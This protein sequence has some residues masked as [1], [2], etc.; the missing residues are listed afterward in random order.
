MAH[1]YRNLALWATM[2]AAAAVLAQTP[3]PS[4]GKLASVAGTVTNS[5][6]GEPLL[7]AH[8]SLQVML[9][10]PQQ[11]PQSYGALTNGEGKF[12]ITQLPPGEYTV[13]VDRVGFVAPLNSGGTRS[14][15]ITLGEGDKKEDL[16]LTLT[17]TGAITGRVLD[18][19]G[20]PVPG[21]NV[22]AEGG[23]QNG[24]STTT[25]DKGQF[26]LGGLRPGRYRV[27]AT[28][29]SLP[30]PPEIR[31][32]GVADMHYAATYYPDS[33]T[34]NSAQRLEVK[35]GAELSGIDVRLVATP[36][37][38]VSGKV[39]GLPP[40]FKNMNVMVQRS[41]PNGG[42]SQS[43]SGVKPDGSFEIWRLDPGKYT[44]VAT[45]FG[46]SGQSRLQSAPLDIEVTTL[47]LEHLELR[48]V[49]EF[50]IAGQVR[51]EDD[52]ARQ[53][54][55]GPAWSGQPQTAA[56]P[57]ASRMVILR[58]EGGGQ[59]VSVELG[60]DDSFRLEKVQSGRFRVTV[61]GGSGYVKSVRAGMTETEGDL[62]DVR[63]GSAGPVTVTVSSNFC[64][65]SG[66]VNDSKG[67]VAN[68]T[69]VMFGPSG[70]WNTQADS[71][72]TYKFTRLPPGRY[73]L[74]ALEDG[75]SVLRR[76][77]DLD[78]YENFVESVDLGAG[79]KITKDLKQ[80]PPGK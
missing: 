78:D 4:T 1:T 36:I 55:Q 75:A 77:E 22:G 37:V 24:M 3:P 8:V 28:P 2:L 57:A 64:E 65:L 15:R 44:L 46:Q 33:L 31:S 76:S 80:R 41:G 53:P 40:D 69:V 49:P 38:T 21:A 58:Q 45:S 7:R 27:K 48:M 63:N 19:A 72:G 47:N 70:S 23:S 20:E 32:D 73:R 11:N 14:A 56:P 13:S 18:A 12:S 39:T 34:G 5:L 79:D 30:L 60:A 17:P 67:P 71:S 25:D 6:T 59:S 54:P 68:A 16:K 26:R 43:A 50:D 10:G 74:V 62:L 35:S 29:Q 52:Q 51:F 9:S 61:S 66:R 42:Y